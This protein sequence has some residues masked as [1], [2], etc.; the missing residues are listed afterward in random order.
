MLEDTREYLF[1]SSGLDCCLSLS[2]VRQ[3]H[4]NLKQA[5]TARR[6]LLL[7]L[8][9]MIKKTRSWYLFLSFSKV[10]T[11]LQTIL[12]HELAR[13]H[14]NPVAKTWA[15]TSNSTHADEILMP[16]HQPPE[17]ADRAEMLSPKARWAIS[18]NKGQG[19]KD[20][21]ASTRSQWIQ[22]MFPVATES[23]RGSS[24]SARG[25]GMLCAQ[26]QQ[27][28]PS[29]RTLG[30]SAP[31][32]TD[33]LVDRVSPKHKNAAFVELNSRLFFPAPP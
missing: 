2:F 32:V 3:A 21:R 28:L 29:R 27:P 5:R 24:T 22:R 15:A 7:S 18:R 12:Q 11:N 31:D 26:L 33:A 9:P 23:T 30:T 25:H 1:S 19:Q 8:F 6:S 10:L 13:P 17:M 20:P 14:I 4:A 16:R